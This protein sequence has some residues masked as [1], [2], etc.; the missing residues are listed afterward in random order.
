MYILSIEMDRVKNATSLSLLLASYYFAF[1]SFSESDIQNNV[2]FY[3]VIQSSIV[4]NLL[5]LANIMR[6]NSNDVLTYFTCITSSTAFFTFVTYAAH[7]D[8]N[9]ASDPLFQQIYNFYSGS[10]N[11]G[12]HLYILN[13]LRENA[14]VL[15]NGQG[16]R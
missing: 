16:S 3:R 11:A 15:W 12:I 14:T 4:L 10:I 2:F 6:T 9:I 1:G 8:V 5:S 13:E 7:G